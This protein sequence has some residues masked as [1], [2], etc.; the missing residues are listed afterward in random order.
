MATNE[1]QREDNE[2][3]KFDETAG[4]IVVRTK[5]A[6]TVGLVDGESVKITDGTDD[7][8]VVENADDTTDLEDTNGLVTN[9]VLNARI[10][11]TAIRPLRIDSLTHSTQS[12]TQ[13]HHE[14]HDGESYI[15]DAEETLA[16]SGTLVFTFR[17][18]NTTKWIHLVIY[19]RASGEAN[20]NLV[21]NPTITVSTGTSQA[22]HNRNRNS[23]N[24]TTLSDSSS[25]S[26]VPGSITLGATQSGGTTIYTEHIGSGK[27]IGG[28]TPDRME[29]IL[30]QNEDYT[31][32]LTSEA[33][34]ND[35]ELI[36]DWYEHTN[37]D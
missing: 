8:D 28:S 27:N 26:W 18:P 24:V 12:V 33:A 35:C 29:F 32:I 37:R 36:L 21:E 4:K 1:G 30:K 15:T 22:A 9:S 6:E 3:K 2:G 34:T 7:A 14:I 10:S 19:A 11:N 16:S 25:G 20:I 31:I 23:A 13:P 17:T 5:V